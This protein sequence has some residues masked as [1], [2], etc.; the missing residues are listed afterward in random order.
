MIMVVVVV[1]GAVVV[2]GRGCG[3]L[4][5]AA[6]GG[7]EDSAAAAAAAAAV[8]AKRQERSARDMGYFAVAFRT[9]AFRFQCGV[10]G[11]VF[12]PGPDVPSQLQRTLMSY[13]PTFSSEDVCFSC[14][15][16]WLPRLRTTQRSC[17]PYLSACVTIYSSEMPWLVVCRLLLLL[18]FHAVDFL[19][20]LFGK[21]SSLTTCEVCFQKH[22]IREAAVAGASL[23]LTSRTTHR[24]RSLSFKEKWPR[25]G[26]RHSKKGNLR[27]G[28]YLRASGSGRRPQRRM[29]RLQISGHYAYPAVRSD[30]T[31]APHFCPRATAAGSLH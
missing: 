4:V 12:S 24:V 29:A 28:C 30:L 31:P 17:Q 7:V 22:L 14:A 26:H 27:N 18:P 5:L 9:T 21:H 16:V 1:V 19:S 11:L 3:T 8:V 13:L 10:S 25:D 23:N 2:A 20:I 6:V 15:N